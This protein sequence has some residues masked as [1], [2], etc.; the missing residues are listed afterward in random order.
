VGDH[1]Y[2]KGE[3]REGRALTTWLAL[4]GADLLLAAGL[5]PMWWCGIGLP[6]SEVF[7]RDLQGDVDIFAGPC[8]LLG[9]DQ[10]MQAR[11]RE[12]ESRWPPETHPS[13]FV[14]FA[15]LRAA[16]EHRILWPP[17][18]EFLVGI[19]AK[20]SWFDPDKGVWKATHSQEGSRIKGQ[21][22]VLVENGVDRVAFLHLAST[23]PR[24]A[25]VNPWMEALGDLKASRE[26]PEAPRPRRGAAACRRDREP[27]PAL[28]FDPREVDGCAYYQGLIAGVPH[29][30]EV[31]SGALSPLDVVVSGRLRRARA[32][33][34]SQWRRNLRERLGGLGPP[35]LP[36]V[37]L[38][39][40]IAHGKW[41]WAS[42]PRLPADPCPD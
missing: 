16:A 12:E 5:G 29:A 13:R 4:Q 11:V 40:C 7:C 26:C 33:P 21:L 41:C 9:G 14:E 2:S 31:Q 38:A 3:A 15:L 20:A 28:L 17:R 37:F 24:T 36:G 27:L 22:Q 32:E 34:I 18:L 23:K 1:L 30:P 35:S 8:E 25:E 39:P 10:E 42:T 6:R 19:E